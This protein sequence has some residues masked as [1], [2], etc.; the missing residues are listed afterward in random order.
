LSDLRIRSRSDLK[1]KLQ[2]FIEFEGVTGYTSFKKNG[3]VIKK[4]YLLQIE[5]NQ[6]VQLNGD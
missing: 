4:L 3:D 1:E 5:D 2:N 6:F